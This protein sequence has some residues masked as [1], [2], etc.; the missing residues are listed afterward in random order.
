MNTTR[1]IELRQSQGWTQERLATESGVG[2]RTVQRLEAGQDAS[3]ETLSLVADALKV[4]VR[5]LF[6]VIEDE[7]L[8]MRVDSLEDRTVEQQTARDRIST[9]WRWLYVG[10]GIICTLVAFTVPYGVV[11]VLSYWVGGF[12]ILRALRR[13]VIEPRLDAAYPLSKE[14]PTRRERRRAEAQRPAETP[15]ESTV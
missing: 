4:P 2:L 9:A 3:L 1:I 11:L 14:R 15:A 6:S 10:V 7:G 5:E 12:L 8:S 13:I